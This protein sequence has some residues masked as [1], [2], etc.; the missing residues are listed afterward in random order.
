M[1]SSTRISLIF[2]GSMANGSSERTTMSASLPDSSVHL[3][4]SSKFCQAASSVMARNASN[5]VMPH[6]DLFLSHIGITTVSF[7][8]VTGIAATACWGIRTDEDMPGGVGDTF[9]G[10]GPAFAWLDALWL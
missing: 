2:I 7:T 9:A 1:V 3:R 4:P 8:G 5:G 6:V 10:G